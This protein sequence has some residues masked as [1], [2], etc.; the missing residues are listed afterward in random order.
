LKR[1]LLLIAAL[2]ALGACGKKEAPETVDAEGLDMVAQAVADELNEPPA[3]IQLLL[4]QS[5]ERPQ[6]GWDNLSIGVGGEAYPVGAWLYRH[7]YLELAGTQY[8]TR[9]VFALTEKTRTLL[10]SPDQPWFEAAA[11]EAT[12]VN[13]GTEAALNAGGCEVEVTVTP[14]LTPA[15]R[16]AL[17][18]PKLEPMTVR[19]VVAVAEDGWDVPMYSAA[20]LAPLDVAL[21]AILGPEDGR[22]AADKV[23]LKELGGRLGRA[24]ETPEAAA[25]SQPYQPP[26]YV[27]DPP[28]VPPVE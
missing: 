20:G 14:T 13:C 3:A 24:G 15:G 4:R 25:A 22:E 12:S 10:Q 1:G 17:G 28:P 6:V 27:E 5:A 26:N 23:V 18:S 2:L 19:A 8:V 16:A 21:T 7:G 9:P 11:G